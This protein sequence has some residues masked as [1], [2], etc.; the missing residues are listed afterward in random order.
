MEEIFPDLSQV[1]GSLRTQCGNIGLS[2]HPVAEPR[3]SRLGA[4]MPRAL[5]ERN[6]YFFPTVKLT[7]FRALPSSATTSTRQAPVC[8]G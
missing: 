7:D 4:L 3:G 1:A 5:A 8:I 2:S 6:S